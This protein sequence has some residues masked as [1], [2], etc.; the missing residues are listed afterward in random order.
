[1]EFK[2]WLFEVGDQLSEPPLQ[3]ASG[4]N[5]GAFPRYNK[6]DMPPTGW[7]KKKA[8]RPKSDRPKKIKVRFS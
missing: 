8:T 4:L 2:K 6:N 1:M 5:N 3:P 7:S